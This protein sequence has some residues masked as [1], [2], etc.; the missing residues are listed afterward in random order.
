MLPPPPPSSQQIP[1]SRSLNSGPHMSHA[2]E[3]TS[4]RVPSPLP[5]P[6]GRAASPHGRATSPHGRAALVCPP[7]LKKPHQPV[8]LAAEFQVD[9]NAKLYT[10]RSSPRCEP[11]FSGQRSSSFPERVREPLLVAFPK[12]VPPRAFAVPPPKADSAKNSTHCTLP[13]LR[14]PMP[15]QR[16]TA[17]INSSATSRASPRGMSKPAAGH[18]LPGIKHCAAGLA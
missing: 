3:V 18:T 16:A 1:R 5:S 12:K 8:G 2:V 7:P 11:S 17:D 10:F 9:D 14:P 15:H 4:P 13:R 6:H